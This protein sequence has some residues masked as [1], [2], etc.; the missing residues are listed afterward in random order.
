MNNKQSGRLVIDEIDDKILREKKPNKILNKELY[1]SI[2]QLHSKPN[3]VKV[4]I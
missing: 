4:I 1:Y 3:I 2:P